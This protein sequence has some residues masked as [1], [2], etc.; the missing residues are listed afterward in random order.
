M[1]EFV[2]VLRLSK[3]VP[4]SALMNLFEAMVY[5]KPGLLFLDINKFYNGT[6]LVK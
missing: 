3:Y 1:I 4:S 5:N 6:N 2:N